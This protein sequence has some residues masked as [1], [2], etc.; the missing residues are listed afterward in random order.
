[1]HHPR[2]PQ[3]GGSIQSIRA[4]DAA[5]GGSLQLG[6]QC[7][8][9]I[10]IKLLSLVRVSDVGISDVGEGCASCCSSLGGGIVF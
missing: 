9:R 2:L 8:V 4:E 6:V 5:V 7:E 10:P 3:V 1:M